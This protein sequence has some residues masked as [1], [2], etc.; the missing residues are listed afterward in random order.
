MGHNLFIQWPSCSVLDE[1]FGVADT[2]E[3]F[4]GTEESH[5][6]TRSVSEGKA[7]RSSVT[8][9]VRLKSACESSLPGK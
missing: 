5:R 2:P 8:L 1:T 9:R 7:R 4:A 6:P 3:Y